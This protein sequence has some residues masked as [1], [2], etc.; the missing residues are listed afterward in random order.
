LR[1]TPPG[2]HVDVIIIVNI[3]AGDTLLMFNIEDGYALL[4]ITRYAQPAVHLSRCS[5]AY[6]DITPPPAYVSPLTPPAPEAFG[7]PTLAEIF[8]LRRCVNISRDA[9]FD[10]TYNIIL[11]LSFEFVFTL[12]IETFTAAVSVVGADERRPEFFRLMPP[13]FA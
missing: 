8:S 3:S 9:V 6:A 10:T 4:N 11:P 12:P 13:R 1:A 5:L 2:F 7:T